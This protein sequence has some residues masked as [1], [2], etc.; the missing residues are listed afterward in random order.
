M[1]HK[2]I[3]FFVGSEEVGV[4]G[5]NAV[6]RCTTDE[7]RVA[8]LLVILDEELCGEGKGCAILQDKTVKIFLI[9]SDGKVLLHSIRRLTII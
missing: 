9:A 3:V 1:V 2:F 5:Q 7:D 8:G 6:I 4:V